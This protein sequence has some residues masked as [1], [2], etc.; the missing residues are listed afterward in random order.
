[1][2]RLLFILF[3]EDR[4]LLPFHVDRAYT[5]N[6]S[7]G[8]FRDDIASRLDHIEDGREPEYPPQSCALWED[9][10]TLFDLIDRGAARYKVPAYNGGLF[11]SASH[12]FLSAKKMPDGYLARVIDQLARAPDPA[13]PAGGVVRVDYRNL[14]IQHLGNVYQ[15]HFQRIHQLADLCA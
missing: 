9:L 3:A 5:D 11:D 15:I 12:P 14:A 1:L 7:L 10:L 2:Y 4:K 13:H 6:R 8:R